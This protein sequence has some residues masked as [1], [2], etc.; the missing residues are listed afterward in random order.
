MPPPEVQELLQTS[1][2]LRL[3]YLV[4]NIGHFFSLV[5]T[6]TFPLALTS[7]QLPSAKNH[8]PWQWALALALLSVVIGYSAM[9]GF[10][11]LQWWALKRGKALKQQDRD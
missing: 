11:W 9:R 5:L 4:S 3:I 2:F 6:V 10:G 7:T 8:L 1:R